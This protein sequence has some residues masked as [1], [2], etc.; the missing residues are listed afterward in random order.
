MSEKLAID[1]GEPIR[2]KKM[3]LAPVRGL[4][5]E[6]EKAAAMRVFDEAIES[7]QAFGYNGKYEQAY[8]QA[9]VDFMGGGFADAVNSG[10]NAVFCAL[11]ALQLDALSEV[12]IAPF[13]NEGG[14][15]PVLMA[16]C[17]PVFADSDP[18]SFSICAETIESMITDRT[19][20]I[21]ITH[22][23]GELVDMDPI[24]ELAKAKNLYVIEDC[25]QA[26]GSV[27]KGRLAG[28]IGDMGAFSSMFGKHF[29]TAQG[30]VVY[31]NNE[32]LH[33]NGR[34]F[35]DR[36]KPFNLDETE[37]VVAGLN[38]NLNEL[39]AAVGIEQLKKLPAMLASRRAV[40][41]TIRAGMEKLKSV[42]MVYQPPGS[43]SSC[44]F[45]PT[46]FHAEAVKVDR[47]TFCKALQTEG[48]RI[49]TSYR[50]NLQCESPWFNNATVFGK[51]GFPWTCSDYTGP[52]TPQSKSDNAVKVADTHFVTWLHESYGPT[53]AEDILRAFKKVEEAY[54]I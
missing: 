2:K 46:K 16:G 41:A 51:N 1:G 44:W 13:T 29:S 18:R 8:E 6:E 32:E 23:G 5:G 40:A 45:L 7:G 35:A 14:S 20:A 27:Y 28:S 17:V 22:I 31:T 4:I 43:D 19:K 37:N 49:L 12:I 11:G 36:G 26:I 15:Q 48:L 38:C 52:K 3:W 10:S 34:R 25:A 54:L 39:L 33:W 9:F 21:I 53:E 50:Y 30:G 47:A 42:S 24:M